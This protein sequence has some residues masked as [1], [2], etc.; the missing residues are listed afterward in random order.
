MGHRCE[1]V[2]ALS[3]LLGTSCAGVGD[4]SSACAPGCSGG[5]ICCTEPSHAQANLPDGGTS[6]SLPACVLPDHGVCPALP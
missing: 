5:R 2:V 4:S 1:L 6:H 3:L